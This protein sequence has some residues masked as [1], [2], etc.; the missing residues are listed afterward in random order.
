MSVPKLNWYNWRRYKHI[1]TEKL[2]LW[3]WCLT[4]LSTII[5]LFRGGGNRSTWRKSL[6]CRKSLKLDHIMLYQVHLAW[7]GFELTTL[8][9][10][11]IDCL[12]SCKSN[13]HT[14]TT[15]YS[16][17]TNKN[18][19]NITYFS[20]IIIVLSIIIPISPFSM[21]SNLSPHVSNISTSIMSKIKGLPNLQH[22]YQHYFCFLFN[23]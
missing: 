14:I 3:L 5:Q 16:K 10:I 4:P 23:T 6:T 11:G 2:G 7:V 9:V 18:V 19:Y 21:L 15:A 17:Q 13:Y 22:Y 12:G 1:L 20:S 8:V